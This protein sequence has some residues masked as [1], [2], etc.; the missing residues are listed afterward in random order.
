M[1]LF[2]KILQLGSECQYDVI[3]RWTTGSARSDSD[4]VY[5]AIKFILD[6]VVAA[7]ALPGDG[8]K[9]IRN[10]TH[11]REIGKSDFVQVFF[12]RVNSAK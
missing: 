12:E 1:A 7:G 3:C 6:G 11:T 9:H 5:F 2:A 8:F 10:I 4:N